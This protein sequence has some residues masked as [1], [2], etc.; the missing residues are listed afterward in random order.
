MPVVFWLAGHFAEDMTW[1]SGIGIA[2]LA[3]TTTGAIIGAIHDVSL[4]WLLPRR[5]T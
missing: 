4:L 2:L 3:L 1:H 5:P